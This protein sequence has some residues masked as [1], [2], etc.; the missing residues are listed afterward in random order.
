MFT[1]YQ[2]SITP[3]PIQQSQL[4]K[5]ENIFSQSQQKQQQVQPIYQ[6]QQYLNQQQT[7]V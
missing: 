6:Q 4:N 5:V 1:S 2:Q 7:Q 3:A